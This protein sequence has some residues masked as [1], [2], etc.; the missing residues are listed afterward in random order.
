MAIYQATGLTEG[1]AEPEED[2]VIR[3]RFFPLPQALRMVGS[4][5]IRDGKTIAALLWLQ[6]KP[7]GRE[8]PRR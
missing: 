3:K 5:R 7:G 2:E 4:G 8:K 6:C 1:E